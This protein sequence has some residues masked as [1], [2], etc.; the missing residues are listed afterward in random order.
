MNARAAHRRLYRQIPSFECKP[1]CT[2]CCGIVPLS[3]YEAEQLGLPANTV[4]MPTKP[5]SLTCQY[6]TNEG[7]SVYDKRPLLCRLYGTVDNPHLT[8]PFGCGAKT[9]LT[10]QQGAAIRDKYIELVSL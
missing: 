4:H 8:C 3:K 7:C 1:G 10:D 5:D 6:A 2:G 9:K